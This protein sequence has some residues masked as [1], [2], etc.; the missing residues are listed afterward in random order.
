MHLSPRQLAVLVAL[1]LI[2][3]FNWPIMKLGVTAFPPLSF[4]A[5][6]MWLGLPVLLAAMRLLRVPLAVPRAQWHELARLTATNMLSWHVLAILAVQALS[7][8]R[9]AILGYT[10]PVFSALWG[11]ALFGQRLA[12]RQAAGVLA[13]AVGIALLLWHEFF[14][15]AGRPLGALMMLVAAAVWA[16]G[17]QQLRHTSMT[18]PTL[19]IAFWMTVLT[20]L[21]M[22]I[23]AAIVERPQWRAP[24]AVVW[25]AIVF[26]A[27]AVFGYA[28]PA[29]FYLARTLPPV[30]S[31]L[32]VMFIPVLGVVAGA[33]W[34]GETLHWQ[35]FAAIVLMVAAIAS[36]LWPGRGAPRPAVELE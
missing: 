15:L 12:P 27:V 30:A 22:T 29:W 11:R 26:N 32:S 6:S 23:L 36:V 33:L 9:A 16:L 21:V 2:W 1:T 25:A 8:G 17:T 5:L 19:A 34:L 4:R 14:N 10:M 18:V 24:D 31:T 13:A 7:S 20:T 3:G 28:Q 35:D